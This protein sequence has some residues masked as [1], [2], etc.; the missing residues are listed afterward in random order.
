MCARS[1]FSIWQY[2]KI[3]L[4]KREPSYKAR[5]GSLDTDDS[6]VTHLSHDEAM[7]VLKVFLPMT[8]SIL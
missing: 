7:P 5:Q 1:E 3:K 6:V 8:T 2:T 4:T